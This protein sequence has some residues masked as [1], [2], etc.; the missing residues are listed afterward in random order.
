MQKIWLIILLLLS[1]V[2]GCGEKKQTMLTI[3]GALKEEVGNA[4]LEERGR[5]ISWYEA[6]GSNRYY[7]TYGEAVAIFSPGITDAIWEI[8]VAGES[9]MW[10]SG[11]SIS[12]YKEGKFCSLE[13][14]YENGILT[15]ENVK[16]IADYHGWF[17]K[18]YDKWEYK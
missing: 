15:Q 12:V 6:G 17:V 3:S 16:S 7:G 1:I 4:W 11:F 5:E 10:H 9:L 14:A 13:E 18:T 8:N 2:S